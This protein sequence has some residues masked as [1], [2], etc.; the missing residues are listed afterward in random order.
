M[1]SSYRRRAAFIAGAI[2]ALSVAG[3]P[4]AHADAPVNPQL[5]EQDTWGG[6]L[7]LAGSNIFDQPVV[8]GGWSAFAPIDNTHYWTVSDRGPNGQPTVTVG[9]TTR[10]TRTFLTPSFTP[11]IYK[12]AIG[13]Y[14]Q[15]GVQARIPLHL[16]AG[17][18]DPARAYMAANPDASKGIQGGPSNQ[19]TG[20]P[21]IVTPAQGSASGLPADSAAYK[22]SAARDEVPYAADGVTLLPGDPYGLDTEGI[23]VDPRDGS[24]WLGDEYRPSLIHVA[25]DGTL[26]N[27]IVPQGTANIAADSTD[28]AKFAASDNSILPT[29][30]ALPRAFSYRK[31]NRG[32]EGATL[33]PDGKT[34]FGMLQSSI[35]PPAGKGDART[36]RIVRF[37]VSDPAHPQLT[38]EFIY[39]LET[40]TATSGVKQTDISISDIFALDNNHLLVDEHDNVTDVAGAGQKRIYTA[41]LTNATNIAGDPSAN[42]ENPQVEAQNAAGIV[43]VAKTQVLDLAQFGYNHDKPEGIG[44]FPNGNLAVQDD[45]DFGFN[46]D[47]DP[48]NAGPNDPPFLVT[49]STKTTQLWQFSGLG[50]IPQ[51]ADDD[52][53]GDHPG[54]P[55]NGGSN[56]HPGGPSSGQGGPGKPK[57]GKGPRITFSSRTVSKSKALHLKAV[58]LTIKVSAAGTAKSA[59]T[60][61]S[62]RKTISLGS[63]TQKLKAGKGTL[64][65]SLSATGRK[66][67]SKSHGSV[68]AALTIKTTGSD[69]ATSKTSVH[70]KLK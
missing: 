41:D 26:L 20:L 29:D 43:P 32:M 38:G 66:Q 36:L 18:V 56:N 14:G 37:D 68:T 34:L 13:R 65:V 17:A 3:A 6:A 51:K 63:A 47:N 44:V 46:Q 1:S 62:G 50:L 19:I 61:K 16:K 27:R 33:S 48:E 42:G 22:Q 60:V 49:P 67:L 35:E 69:N 25:P 30:D 39:R 54:G 7:P 4:I 58:K 21:Q 53:H 23:A 8:E 2:A 40:P 10:T 28:P 59:L 12:V 31:Q 11:T 70:I 52:H 57:P 9:G 15:M 5:A 64:I 24:F 45:N 55:D